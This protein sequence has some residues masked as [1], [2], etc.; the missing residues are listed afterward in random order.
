MGSLPRAR[1]PLGTATYDSM[2][3]SRR[4]ESL[5][6]PRATEAAGTGPVA[7][8]RAAGAHA[9]IETVHT[10][11]M[12]AMPG[13]SAQLRRD[14]TGEGRAG[15]QCIMIVKGEEV[16]QPNLVRLADPVLHSVFL[17]YIVATRGTIPTNTCSPAHVCRGNR[18][19]T[20]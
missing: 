17:R 20:S 19:Q 15:R 3:R 1:R 2:N 9:A 18:H 7:A 13:R 16:R 11:T 5:P 12:H 8:C 10:T 6:V 4:D 14:W